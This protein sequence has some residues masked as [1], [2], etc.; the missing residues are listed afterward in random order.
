MR[1]RGRF[2]T[3]ERMDVSLDPFQRKHLVEETVVAAA[4]V[5]GFSGQLGH[6]HKPK[7]TQTVADV[8]HDDGFA[9]SSRA[10]S[11]FGAIRGQRIRSHMVV[12]AA[13]YP[14]LMGGHNVMY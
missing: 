3:S 9:S 11:Q 2:R 7:G 13:M 8:Y 1:G 10:C 14:R 12:A 5:R 4:L 6:G